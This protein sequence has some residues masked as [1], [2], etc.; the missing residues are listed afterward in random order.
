MNKN[1]KQKDV[2]E[3]EIT[4]AHGFLMLFVIIAGYLVSLACCIGCGFFFEAKFNVAGTLLII[5]GI[6][7]FIVFSIM[8]SGFHIVNP[9]EAVVLTLFG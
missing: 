3:H 5:L 9:K 1:K 6:V 4:K 2:V 8:W 7:G